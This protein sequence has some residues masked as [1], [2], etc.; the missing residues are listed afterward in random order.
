MLNDKLSVFYQAVH[1]AMV[2]VGNSAPRIADRVIAEAFPDTNDAAE[3][4][5]ADR[6]LRDGVVDFLTKY[7][8]RNANAPIEQGDFAQISEQFLDIVGRLQSH[9]HY[10]PSLQQHMSVGYLI[11]NPDQ[12]DEARKFKRQKGEETL[13]EAAALDELYEAVVSQ[14]A[15]LFETAS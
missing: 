11:A 5:G 3:R 10:V 4:E 1:D 15:T 13:A 7:L 8:K 6:M 9:S 14:G 2:D 12:L